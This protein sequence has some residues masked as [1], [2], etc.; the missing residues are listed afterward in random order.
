MSDETGYIDYDEMDKKYPE[1]R[2]NLLT[3][4]TNNRKEFPDLPVWKIVHLL[5]KVCRE[6][7]DYQKDFN[8]QTKKKSQIQIEKQTAE[9]KSQILDRG[10]EIMN[11][12]YHLRDAISDIEKAK[13]DE[14]KSEAESQAEKERWK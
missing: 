7:G 4:I 3:L 13:R 5:G 2:K 9:L 12:E 8:D 10:L 14:E 6:L 1:F 11:N